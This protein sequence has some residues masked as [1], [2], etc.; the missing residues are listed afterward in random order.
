[1]KRFLM[2]ATALTAMKKVAFAI[3]CGTLLMLFA[4]P[5]WAQTDQGIC[6]G[7]LVQHGDARSLGTATGCGALITVTAVDGSGKATAFTVTLFPPNNNGNPYD[8]VEDT[9]IGV[10][11][12]SNGTLNSITL[13]STDT[14]FGGIFNFDADGPCQYAQALYGTSQDCFLVEGGTGY[15]G[16]NDT[17]SGINSI[18]CTVNNS[19]ATCH[20][21]GTVNF[22]PGISSSCDGP[23]GA[24][25]ALEGTPNSLVFVGP[26][27]D[28]TGGGTVDL[29]PPSAPVT[30]TATFPANTTFGNVVFMQLIETPVDPGT[31]N[32]GRFPPTG[33]NTFSK[34][35][36][37]PSSAQ[38]LAISGACISEL[39]LCFDKT[40]TQIPCDGGGVPANG[41][42]LPSGTLIN[43]L[44]QFQTTTPIKNPAVLIASDGKND[45]ANITNFFDPGDIC[46]KPPCKG[47][48]GTGG[49]NSEGV[50]ADLNLPCQ[51]L[52]YTLSP[53][54]GSPGT[55]I[56]VTGNLSGCSS[57][58]VKFG[59]KAVLFGLVLSAKATFRTTGPMDS[60][61]TIETDTSSPIQL[62]LP[63]GLNIPFKFKV[64]IPSNACTGTFEL[65]SSVI[66][67]TV[68]YIGSAT[69]TVP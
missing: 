67:G 27:T 36:P 18:P 39:F 11:N 33:T 19:P 49:F 69:L 13:N 58:L 9:L 41:I 34:G 56:N 40:H 16:Q 65:T 60:T 26:Q 63:F 44:S 43:L 54:H 21:G 20:T 28:V 64:K 22:T 14:T 68:E 38:C 23:C 52:T 30:Q 8:G 32:A 42:V 48:G 17:F 61:C 46:T 62:F 5:A 31:F 15:E 2:P 12:S 53:T 50:L 47:G 29:T 55:I 66:S 10:L 7:A 45:W 6:N 57:Q 25:F 4:T 1:M 59:E 37:V 3:L 24:F 51:V 35:S